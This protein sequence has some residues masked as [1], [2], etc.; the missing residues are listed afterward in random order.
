M[1]PT[2]SP[3]LTFLAMELDNALLYIT[4][5]VLGFPERYFEIIDE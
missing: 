5:M 3:V 4:N 2:N 1:M